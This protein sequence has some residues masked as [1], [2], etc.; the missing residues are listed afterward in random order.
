MA[1]STPAEELALTVNRAMD[2]RLSPAKVHDLVR[3][4]LDRLATAWRLEPADMHRLARRMRTHIYVP[5]EIIVPRGAHAECLGL[6]VRGQVAVHP[7]ERA[8]VRPVVVLLPG[9]TFGEAM[10]AEGRPSSATLQALTRCE[11]RFLRRA[12]LQALSNRRRTERWVATLRRLITWTVLLAAV[13]LA[14]GLVLISP[15]ARRATALV[16]MS[17]GQWCRQQRHDNCAEQAWQTAANLAPTDPNPRLALGTLYFESGEVATAEQSFEAAKALAPDS[18]EAF[19][20]LGLIYARQGNH[21]R[22]IAAFRRALELEPGVAATEHNLALSLQATHAYDEALSHYKSALALDES[23]PST[24]VNMAIAY[25]EAGQLVAAGNMARQALSHDQMLAPAYMVLGAVALDSRQP[26]EALPYLRRA[27]A[28]DAN[29]SQVHFYLGLAYKSLGQ[30][31]EALAAFEQALT[32]AD[33][34]V[35]RVRIRRH[36]NELY[37]AEGQSSGP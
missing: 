24:L 29:S 7:G 25:Y 18:P 13:L 11:I 10:L 23:Q 2:G 32:T 16:P 5:G 8:T 33:D 28:L 3:Q 12:D 36:L 4:R 31:T 15:S 26:E 34:E 27:V 37:G 30:I 20:N 6:I 14:V 9:S 21:E 35:M 17:I 22:A 1:G 19:N